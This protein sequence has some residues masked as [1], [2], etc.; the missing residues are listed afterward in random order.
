MIPAVR[1]HQR[2]HCFLPFEAVSECPI[3]SQVKESMEK[4]LTI[5]VSGMTCANCAMNIERTLKKIP[6]IKVAAVNF[7][8]EQA[9]VTFDDASVNP[10]EII[11]A[12]KKA[13]FEPHT[14]TTEFPV[15]GM[16]CA[17]CAM[18]IERT[19]KK[20]PGV[21]A[22]GVNFASERVWVEF[23]PS[24]ISLEAIAA[25]IE[26][27][28]FEAIFPEDGKDPEDAEAQARAAEIKAQTRKFFIGVVF[29]LPLF[30]LSMARDFG[31]A[32]PWS[33]AAWVNW[34][35]LGLATPVQFYTGWDFYTGA[36]KNLKN[37][38]ANMDVL[39][40]MGSSVA[41]FYSLALLFVPIAGQHV[42]FETSA[43]II[44]LI[45]LG[46][47]LESRTKGR[48][49]A[50]IRKLMDLSPK[51]ATRLVD[52][53]ESEVPLDRVHVGDVL[54][55]RPG[56][57]VPV[58]GVVITGESSVDE[59]MLT[60][61]SVPVDKDPGDPVVGGTV[62][63]HGMLTME[64]RKIGRETALAQIIKLVQDAQGS[65]APIQAL[66][67]RVAAVFVPVVI[68]LGLLTFVIWWMVGGEFVPA[69]L[70]LVAVLVIACPC[71]LGLATPTAIMA[72][73]GKGAEK[74]ILF[75]N[76]TALENTARLDYIVLDK[77]GT[78]TAGK[79]VVTDI[80]TAPAS[81]M[82]DDDV[83]TIAATVER[84]SEH[85]LGKSIVRAAEERGRDFLELENF[86]SHSGSGVEALVAG[87]RVQVGKPGWFKEIEVDLGKIN[88]AIDI[89]QKAGKTAMIVARDQVA[90]GVIAVAD[91]VKPDSPEA[92][93]QLGRQG[94]NVMMI[95]GDNARTAR[96]IGDQVG[97]DHIFA[98]VQPK[99][100]AARVKDLQKEG[101]KVAM[102]GDGI[103]DAPALAQA[104]VGIAI[105]SGTD[106]AIE[107]AGVILSGGSLTGV[108]A[109]IEL[110]RA[111]MRT[112]RQNLFWAFFYN[113]ILI[114]VAAGVLYPFEAAPDFLR[115]LHPI[116]AALAM[117]LSSISVVSNS[118]RLYRN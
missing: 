86:R 102:V 14:V 57:S 67:D 64:A 6:G 108:P 52:G 36:W 100:K 48:T 75:K 113:I 66:A 24:E 87:H 13:G 94:L 46:K 116:F 11:A 39:V 33:H 45:K 23:L 43:V 80:Q 82:N 60:G 89:F 54:I 106:V 27:T 81:G 12:I 71:A 19:L 56:Q 3:C 92:V 105:G 8:S 98:E 28:G 104:E 50:A 65:K 103:N 34:F 61:E 2:R 53:E 16:T 84:G 32:G 44:T 15:S 83:L 62:N 79:P 97:V 76:S 95:T 9:G 47:M 70:R 109:A 88:A 7:V 35:F 20:T 101:R 5:P 55:V 25:G 107:T 112:I 49:G 22:A 18:N 41:Y 93:A 29:T 51:T 74:G 17:N 42:Y 26:K 118:L 78:I 63:G 40:A 117:S 1:R 10:P 96:A 114:P 72:G 21:V 31:I 77:T 59:S 110:S 58:D 91:T 111:T 85:P 69:M 37:M 38:T 30:L 115:S 4:H 99:D 73:T 68:G 90:I